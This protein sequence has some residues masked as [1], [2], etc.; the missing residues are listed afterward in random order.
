MYYVLHIYRGYAFTLQV[1]RHSTRIRATA[2]IMYTICLYTNLTCLWCREWRTIARVFRIYPEI[3]AHC[4][5]SNVPTHRSKDTLKFIKNSIAIY[6]SIYFCLYYAFDLP[7][8]WTIFTWIY[9]HLILFTGPLQ[10]LFV[11]STW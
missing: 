11:N 6:H 5:G 2:C 4:G 9:V 1:R 3:H 8:N 7:L 10:F